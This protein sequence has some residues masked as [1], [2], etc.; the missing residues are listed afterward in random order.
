MLK[1]GDKVRIIRLDIADENQSN[2]KIG[3][4][5]TIEWMY[6]TDYEPFDCCHVRF[7]DSIIFTSSRNVNTDGT[8]VMYM[9]QLEA[10]EE[11][12]ANRR[13]SV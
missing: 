13:E 12:E 4:I 1:I 7:P 2:L 5:G 11:Q 10:I 8:Y 6:E 9:N 3:D